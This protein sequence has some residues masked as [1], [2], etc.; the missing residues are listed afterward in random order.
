[1][2]SSSEVQSGEM[3]LRVKAT[4]TVIRAERERK[5]NHLYGKEKSIGP[6]STLIDWN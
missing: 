4:P 1:M 6:A 3:D 5:N 2:T